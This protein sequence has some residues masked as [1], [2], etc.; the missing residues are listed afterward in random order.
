MT[1]KIGILC[2]GRSGEHEVSLLSA[3]SI[4]D[5]LDRKR[6]APLLVAIDKQGH[7]R[8]GTPQTLLLHADDA[9]RIALNPA[10]PRVVPMAEEGVC[11]LPGW[12]DESVQL[13]VELFFPII[14]GTDGEDGAL[15]GL[16]R[17]WD[18]PFVGADV[19]GSALGMDKDVTKR[20]LAHAG[21]PVA[22]WVTL[23]RNTREEA[24]FARLSETLGLPLFVKPATLGSSVGVS[25]VADAPALDAALKAA[26]RYDNKVLVEQA[27][28]GREI[29]CSVLGSGPGG[30]VPPRA[31]LPGEVVPR[32]GFYSYAA[33]YL[34]ADGAELHVP[35]K[36][37]AGTVARVQ[38]LAVRVFEVLECDGMGR[39]D[40]F[41]MPDGQLV[42]N[43][44]NTLPGFT[45]ISM[46]PKLWAAS[47]LPYPE[48]L[49]RLVDLALAR[50]ARRQA[51]QRDF[52]A[53]D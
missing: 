45:R 13:E 33:K 6:F 47:G 52:T 8:A 14:H 18:L 36:L 24:A 16:L 39:V 50:H 29:E 10:A 15:Q 5:A 23:N 9:A 21:L 38:A 7:W 37:D 20:L 28:A 17:M 27:I 53:Q 43:E 2:G 4:Y 35:A 34:E 22:R 3:R 49:S 48:L 25:R 31:S 44:I 30:D 11:L 1:I 46:Y 19:L 40:F 26:F 51:L 41:L 12:D 42:V 32:G